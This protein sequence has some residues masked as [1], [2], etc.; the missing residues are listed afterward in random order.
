MALTYCDVAPG[1][2]RHRPYHDQEYGFPLVPGAHAE[3]CPV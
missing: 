2:E 3:R 1:H